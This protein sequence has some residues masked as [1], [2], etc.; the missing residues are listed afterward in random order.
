MKQVKYYTKIS[1]IPILTDKKHH[2]LSPDYRKI[3]VDNDKKIISKYL[4]TEKTIEVL[5]RDLYKEYLRYDYDWSFKT[6]S[7]ARKVNTE[8]EICYIA[9]MPFIDGFNKSGTIIN[10]ND[11][12]ALE[13]KYYGQIATFTTPEFFR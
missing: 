5:L 3:L 6:I 1:L 9:H 4:S 13:D 10:I 7:S 2:Q 12:H 11:L 8:I